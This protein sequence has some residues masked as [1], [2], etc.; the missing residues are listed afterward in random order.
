M[1]NRLHVRFLWRHKIYRVEKESWADENLNY[2][3]VTWRLDVRCLWEMPK[4]SILRFL[5]LNSF[6]SRRPMKSTLIQWTRAVWFLLSYSPQPWNQNRSKYYYQCRNVYCSRLIDVSINISEARNQNKSVLKMHLVR[7]SNT[8]G[9][10]LSQLSDNG[11]AVLYIFF[12]LFLN[13]HRSIWWN[14]IIMFRTETGLI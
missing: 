5:F 11:R 2:V 14:A 10:A 4:T 7:S 6:S 12:S 9:S 1:E 13:I 3:L 8:E